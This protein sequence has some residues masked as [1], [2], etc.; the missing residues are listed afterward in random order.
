LAQKKLKKVIKVT[1]FCDFF[2]WLLFFSKK[3]KKKKLEKTEEKFKKKKFFFSEANFPHFSVF[4]SVVS[5]F[6]VTFYQKK[7]TSNGKIFF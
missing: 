2:V 1:D 6:F 4:F 5:L 3:V 7:V